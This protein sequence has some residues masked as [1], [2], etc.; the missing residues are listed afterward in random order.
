VTTVYTSDNISENERTDTHETTFQIFS[1]DLSHQGDYEM[2]STARRV[3]ILRLNN[4][5]PLLA[6]D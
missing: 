4:S 2:D 6:S 3:D 1:F 5:A